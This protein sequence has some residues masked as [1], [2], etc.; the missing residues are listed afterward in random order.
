VFEEIG[1]LKVDM[2]ENLRMV[3]ANALDA[4]YEALFLELGLPPEQ[5]EALRAI[6]LKYRGDPYRIPHPAYRGSFTVGE[7]T[8]EEAVTESSLRAELAA[9]FTPAQ[10]EAFERFEADMPYRAAHAM[11]EARL[12]KTSLPDTTIARIAEVLT[13]ESLVTAPPAPDEIAPFFRQLL[14]ANDAA[15]ARL[16]VELSAEDLAE[17][18]RMFEQDSAKYEAYRAVLIPEGEE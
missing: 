2:A 16:S 17:V 6:L 9:L 18:E 3:M 11:H 10:L 5:Q 1:A 4:E 14:E 8:F 7:P 13:E 12:A 15:Y